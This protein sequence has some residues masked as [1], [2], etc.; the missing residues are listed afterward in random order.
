MKIRFPRAIAMF[1]AIIAIAAFFQPY[2]NATEE[3][4]RILDLAGSK[5][6]YS[7]ADLTFSDMKRMTLFDYAKVY[8]QAGQE[9]FPDDTIR[10]I[11]TALYG[12]IVVI[13]FLAFLFAMGRK[14][15]LLLLSTLLLGG[16]AYLINLDFLQRGIMPD[17]NQVWGIAHEILLP[18]SELLLVFA[19]WMLIAK[20]IDKKRR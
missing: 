18:V 3:Y 15:F 8:L 6:V 4:C 10:I 1:L 11:Y 2:I 7:T 9:I 16:A 13:A 17:N 12:S 5:K 20:R 14:P 19:V